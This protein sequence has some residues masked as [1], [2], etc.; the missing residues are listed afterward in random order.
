M[1]SGE[2]SA[3]N[4]GVSSTC[5]PAKAIPD[6]LHDRSMHLTLF[7]RNLALC[8]GARIA[9]RL[10][11]G[12]HRL[13]ARPRSI[14][15]RAGRPPDQQNHEHEDARGFVVVP[16]R[17]HRCAAGRTGRRRCVRQVQCGARRAR[18]GCGWAQ[19]VTLG[20][21]CC[22]ASSHAS[23]R[24]RQDRCAQDRTAPRTVP[25]TRRPW[26]AL[27]ADK[28]P[29]RR[30]AQGPPPTSTAKRSTNPRPRAEGR[31]R[32]QRGEPGAQASWRWPWFRARKLRGA[33]IA[34]RKRQDHAGV[35]HHRQRVTNEGHARPVAARPVE[36]SRDGQSSERGTASSAAPAPRRGAHSD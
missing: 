20:Q 21:T 14:T 4:A 30:Q 27:G 35:C 36:A 26:S 9:A 11:L 33:A 25:E 7:R 2:D 32:I 28:R 24:D 10:E 8:S 6:V 18:R 22:R 12:S 34:C 31:R 29:R 15:T 17:R 13:S 1:I 5:T 19:I 23:P 3:R 16:R